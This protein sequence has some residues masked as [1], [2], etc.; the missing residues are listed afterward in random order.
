MTYPKTLRH[1][2]EHRAR[3][4]ST[5]RFDPNTGQPLPESRQEFQGEGD[6]FAPV[7]VYSQ[8]QEEQHRAMGYLEAG[9]TP[10]KPATA[11][12]PLC[13]T[14]PNQEPRI[15]NTPAEEKALAKLGYARPGTYDPAAVESAYASPYVPGRV[16]QEYPRYEGGRIVQDPN[17]KPDSNEYPKW[18]KTGTDA[19]GDPMGVIV[20]SQGE[21]AAARVKHGIEVAPAA[22]PALTLNT[23]PAEATPP[24]TRGQKI[25][26]TKA[27]KKAER[28][29]AQQTAA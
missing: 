8:E 21:E 23:L 14:C 9:E 22:R 4:R 18:L 6:R 25:A 7:T 16:T 28:E 3:S 24:L 11:E 13:M 17:A 10:A 15:V 29:A 5:G 27:R 19:N 20:N 1:P 26:A 2:A 12:Y